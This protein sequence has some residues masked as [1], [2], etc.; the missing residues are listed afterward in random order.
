M[1]ATL[2]ERGIGV[3]PFP[4]QSVL[5]VYV[6]SLKVALEKSSC[7]SNDWLDWLAQKECGI[8]AEKDTKETW[9]NLVDASFNMSYWPAIQA[10]NNYQCL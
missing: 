1:N 10:G 2:N 4:D 6:D 3:C 7:H 8:G 5:Q 9:N